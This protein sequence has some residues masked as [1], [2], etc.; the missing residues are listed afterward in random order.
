MKRQKRNYTLRARAQQE[1]ATRERILEAIVHL[2]QEVGPARTTIAA[3]AAQAGVQ[4][5]TVYR[6]FPSE[7]GMME[8]CSGLFMQRN[9][10]PDPESWAA[11]SDPDRRLAA[12]LTQI[13][14]YYARTRSMFEK[15][16][17]D[18]PQMEVVAR[19]FSRFGEWIDQTALVLLDG[20][21]LRGRK[22][23]LT[24]QTIRHALDFTTWQSLEHQGLGEKE[25]VRLVASWLGGMK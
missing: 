11:I 8:A 16:V 19:Q 24:A 9:P 20:R 17:Q 18:A 13:Y 14:G 2:H 1:A 15:I 3:I 25:K 22:K 12:A 5:L 10:A 6:H 21:R 7:K 4:R 23:E